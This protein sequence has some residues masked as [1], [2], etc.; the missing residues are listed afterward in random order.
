MHSTLR[1]VFRRSCWSPDMLIVYRYSIVGASRC[2]CG[3]FT[4]AMARRTCWPWP[5]QSSFPF[6]SMAPAWPSFIVFFGRF[7]T[8]SFIHLLTLSST[9]CSSKSGASLSGCSTSQPGQPYPHVPYRGVWV[10]ARVLVCVCVCVSELT[11]AQEEGGSLCSPQLKGRGIT[12]TQ[13]LIKAF[14][15]PMAP[16][17]QS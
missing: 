8:S 12:G 9:S 11:V 2:R 3:Q 13:T 6:V 7:P 17:I 14:Q 10:C 1:S 16:L 5:L 4:S 15:P